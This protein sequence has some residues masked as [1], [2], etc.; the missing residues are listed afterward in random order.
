M[1]LD[2]MAMVK[3]ADRWH[4]SALVN[5]C[6]AFGVT[7][8]LVRGGGMGTSGRGRKGLVG[9]SKG[10]AEVSVVMLPMP[11]PIGEGVGCGGLFICVSMGFQVLMSPPELQPVL[12][13]SLT[14]PFPIR[15]RT[16]SFFLVHIRILLRHPISLT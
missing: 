8:E 15:I 10:A 7:G 14:P 6:D 4:K 12:S 11:C 2:Q 9:Q 3:A 5:G 1:A 16:S 13:H